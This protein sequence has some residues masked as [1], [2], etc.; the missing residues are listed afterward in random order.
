MKHFTALQGN[1][2]T[3]RIRLPIVWYM[4]PTAAVQSG[5]A[6][7]DFGPGPDD[8]VRE[9]PRADR[10]RPGAVPSRDGRRGIW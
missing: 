5:T 2:Q 9:V 4:L 7:P 8:V 10:S 6:L 1:D 3:I